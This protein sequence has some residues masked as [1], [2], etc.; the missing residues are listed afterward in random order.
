[1][2]DVDKLWKMF[3]YLSFLCNLLSKTNSKIILTDFLSKIE[4]MVY[5]KQKMKVVLSLA[6][7]LP[8]PLTLFRHLLNVNSAQGHIR[9]PRSFLAD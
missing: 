2:Q 7:D 5:F 9:D 4:M 3:I 8:L 1:M 6:A